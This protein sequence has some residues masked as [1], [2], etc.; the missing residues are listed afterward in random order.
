MAKL[1]YFSETLKSSTLKDIQETFVDADISL[2][3]DIAYYN[4]W[5]SC[6]EHGGIL[7]FKAIDDSIQMVSFGHSVFSEDDN[8]YFDLHEIDEIQAL[9]EIDDMEKLIQEQNEVLYV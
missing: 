4:W 8:N 7:I 1:N 2:I 9:K 5:T 3:S 6:E